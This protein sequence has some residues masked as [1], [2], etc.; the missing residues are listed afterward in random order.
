[1]KNNV[2]YMI[3]IAS[4]VSY[5][6][7]AMDAKEDADE[8]IIFSYKVDFDQEQL[9]LS[10]NDEDLLKQSLASMIN[11]HAAQ[12][13]GNA[14]GQFFIKKDCTLA[15]SFA[16][17]NLTHVDVLD[18]WPKLQKIDLPVQPFSIEIE[19]CTWVESNV[20]GWNVMYHDGFETM[21]TK[22]TDILKASNTACNVDALFRLSFLRVQNQ[23]AF[24][25]KDDTDFSDVE[26]II[27]DTLIDK[28]DELYLAQLRDRSKEMFEPAHLIGCIKGI[29]ALSRDGSTPLCSFDFASSDES[30]TPSS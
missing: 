3:M 15:V 17:R 9:K 8:S 10:P 22:I 7:K 2:L 28:Y 24:Q 21:H 25:G 26:R 6:L 27:W 11:H 4:L 16:M 14:G 1:M 12:E 30:D 20:M 29:T 5:S 19:N 23:L 13:A 18:L